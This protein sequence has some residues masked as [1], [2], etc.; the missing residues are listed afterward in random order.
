MGA[1]L[2]PFPPERAFDENIKTWRSAISDDVG[3]WLSVDLGRACTLNAIQVDFAEQATTTAGGRDESLSQTY[4]LEASSDG[5]HWISIH[6]KTD[7]NHAPHDY[8]ELTTSTS[9]RYVRITNQ[10]PAAGGGTFADR[11]VP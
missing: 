8:V 6:Q 11:S 1:A 9:V 4:L 5:N 10:G 2:A 3:E 7:E